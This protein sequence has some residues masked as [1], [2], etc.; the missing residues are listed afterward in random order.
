MECGEPFSKKF[1][2]FIL[3]KKTCCFYFDWVVCVLLYKQVGGLGAAKVWQCSE[4][5]KKTKNTNYTNSSETTGN[6]TRAYFE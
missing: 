5:Q 6:V 1:A 4:K 2:V 3:F